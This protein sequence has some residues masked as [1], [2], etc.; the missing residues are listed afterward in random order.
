KTPCKIKE[1][2]SLQQLVD[3]EVGLSD[4][5]E[6][7]IEDLLGRD[8]VPPI[9]ALLNKNIQ[10]KSVMVTGAGGSIGSELCRQILLNHPTK[11]VLFDVSE[12]ALY[13]IHLELLH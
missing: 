4:I 8:P 5:Q 1:L 13:S 12:Y 6:I 10:H 3:G 7:A 2:P 9:T 11:L